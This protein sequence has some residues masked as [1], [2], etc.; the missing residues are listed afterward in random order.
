MQKSLQSLLLVSLAVVSVTI[1]AWVYLRGSSLNKPLTEPFSHP[2]L[3][4][5]REQK[6]VPIAHRGGWL[7]APENTIAAIEKAAHLGPN[8]VLWIDVRPT[9]DG[10]LVLMRDRELS[11]TT[12]GRGWVAMKTFEEIREL[13]AAANFVDGEGKNP[14]SS[15]RL[16]VPR[17]RDVLQTFPDRRFILSF[18]G[19][20]PDLIDDIVKVI[21]ETK[22]SDRVLITSPE[23]RL[24]HDLHEREPTWAYGTS[25]MQMTVLKMLATIGLESMAPIKGDV[26]ILEPEDQARGSLFTLSTAAIDELH[27][28]RRLIISGPAT[29]AAEAEAFFRSGID[30]V[31]LARPSATINAAT[32]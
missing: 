29:N 7:D 4:W 27:R 6:R 21:R 19:N 15:K 17:L 1:L 20:Q 28:R 10:E 32:R 13:N 2:L 8:V 16:V 14:Y 30:A 9:R 18:R 3:N 25:L 11:T 12:D 31:L 22:A 23:D 26:A 5:L 24:L